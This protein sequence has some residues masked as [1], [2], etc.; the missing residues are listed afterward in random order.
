MV[1]VPVEFHTRNHDNVK[2]VGFLAGVFLEREA[3]LGGSKEP[4]PLL[5]RAV[6]SGHFHTVFCALAESLNRSLSL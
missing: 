3:I 6:K 5:E 4:R 2:K 1:D